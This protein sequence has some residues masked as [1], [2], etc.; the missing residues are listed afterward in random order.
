MKIEDVRIGMWVEGTARVLGHPDILAVDHAG[1][2]VVAIESYPS[3]KVVFALGRNPL[4]L[5]RYYASPQA[6]EEFD[7]R[8][9]GRRCPQ[10][11]QGDCRCAC[12]ERF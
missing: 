4:P 7:R 9:D 5:I 8:G 11:R 10:R 6:I 2:R 1:G 12:G 3:E